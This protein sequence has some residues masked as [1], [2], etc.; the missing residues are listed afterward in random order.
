MQ[1]QRK[2]PHPQDWCD[3]F[4]APNGILLS[5]PLVRCGCRS[6][7]ASSHGTHPERC[8]FPERIASEHSYFLP[9]FCHGPLHSHSAGNVAGNLGDTLRVRTR[10]NEE[11]E[12]TY[13]LQTPDACPC[14]RHARIVGLLRV[15]V[16]GH[17]RRLLRFVRALSH[18]LITSAPFRTHPAAPNCF[19]S[20]RPCGGRSRSHIPTAEL[21]P[22]ER[23]D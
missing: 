22:R 23:P 19:H 16:G 21:A 18:V 11:E 10:T 2:A 17:A 15:N 1:S 8:V 4:A 6:S 12:R 3:A 7:P 13:E 5:R 20:T 14:R 9:D